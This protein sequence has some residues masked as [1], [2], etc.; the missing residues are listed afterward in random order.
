VQLFDLLTEEPMHVDELGRAVELPI[1]QV[2]SALAL[3]ELKG[4]VHQVGGM[5]YVRAREA[6]PVYTLD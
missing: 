3:M 4:L 6:G 2:T 1:A 5:N